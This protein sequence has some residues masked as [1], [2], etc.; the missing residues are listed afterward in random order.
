LL[1]VCISFAQINY[2]DDDDD[3]E[4]NCDGSWY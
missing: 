4:M 1:T 2:D 3:D